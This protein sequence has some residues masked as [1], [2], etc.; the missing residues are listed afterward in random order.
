MNKT[1]ASRTAAR[2]KT[3][4][5]APRANAV[6]Q[7]KPGLLAP[8]IF[9]SP[10]YILFAMFGLF[11][12]LFS[13]YVAF[14]AWDPVSGIGSMQF[15]GFE[16]FQYVIL[17]DEWFRKSMLNTFWLALLSGLPQHLVAIPLAFFIH[18]SFKRLRNTVV[19]IYF[20]PFITSIVAVS[21]V[22]TTLFSR[23][24]GV[25]NIVLTGLSDVPILGALFPTENIEW[26]GDADF[27]KPAISFVVWWRYVG[28]NTV[29]YLAA[30]QAIPSE[31]YEAAA[32]DGASKWRQFWHVTLPLLRPMMLF[33][34]IL[35]VIGNLQL[36]EEP[37]ILVG[38]GGG[39][40]Q[41][42]MTTALYMWRTAFNASD[43]DFGTA[44]AMAWILFVVIALFT[45]LTQYLFTR[46]GDNDA[47]RS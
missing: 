6:K 45:W 40:E 18:T 13:L 8:Y 41:A 47:L 15:V 9:I 23:D 25:I 28:F 43:G 17:E 5:S 34:S 33:A 14:N 12:L 29:L 27:V 3:P 4:A 42:G 20:M 35:T 7:R 11:P 22:F 31:L 1:T 38:A 10:F 37:L 39:P 44:S 16:N 19:G 24:F 30:L 32:M 21:L 46:G 2:S 26:L 36:L